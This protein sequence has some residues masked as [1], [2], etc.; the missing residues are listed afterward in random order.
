[1]NVVDLIPGMTHA[2]LLVLR[3]NAQRFASLEED[4]RQQKAVTLLSVIEAELAR[5][6]VIEASAKVAKIKSARTRTA[7]GP[8]RALATRRTVGRAQPPL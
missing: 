5:R 4:P 3:Q 7:A 2:E 8:A 1:M 6:T